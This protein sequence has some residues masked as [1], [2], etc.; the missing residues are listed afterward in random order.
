MDPH[1]AALDDRIP[2][3]ARLTAERGDSERTART[4][5]VHRKRTSR[6]KITRHAFGVNHRA[7]VTTA[8]GVAFHHLAP[9][10]Y[11]G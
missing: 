2:P 7:A 5:I 6:M 4:R 10:R 1:H 3:L 11:F 9:M 8:Q